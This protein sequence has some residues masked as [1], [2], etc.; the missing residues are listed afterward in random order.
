LAIETHCTLTCCLQL[1]C[2]QPAAGC[3]TCD[4]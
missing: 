2:S 3:L 4:G 1:A